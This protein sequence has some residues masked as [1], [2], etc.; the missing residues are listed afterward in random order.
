MTGKRKYLRSVTGDPADRMGIAHSAFTLSGLPDYAMVLVG[1]SILEEVLANAIRRCT[2]HS[3]PTADLLEVGGALGSFRARIEMAFALGWFGPN[4]A[5]DLHT[6]RQLRNTFAHRFAT[7][8]QQGRFEPLSFDN[9]EIA[10]LCQSLRL[11][12]RFSRGYDYS[13][14]TMKDAPPLP[15]SKVPRERFSQVVMLVWRFLQWGGPKARPSIVPGR[16]DLP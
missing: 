13:K 11:P 6:I 14:G 1:A 3:E 2:V 12:S 8:D 10:R 7:E 9:R 16:P 5:K 15:E 4:T